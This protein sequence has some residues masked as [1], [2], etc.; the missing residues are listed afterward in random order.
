MD[1]HVLVSA[2]PDAVTLP[3][4]TELLVLKAR[5]TLVAARPIPTLKQSNTTIR[6]ERIC[7]LNFIVYLLSLAPANLNR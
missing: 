1:T 3:P 7:A 4:T 5:V 6:T 2:V